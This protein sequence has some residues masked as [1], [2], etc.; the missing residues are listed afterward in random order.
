[1]PESPRP[2]NVLWLID[3]VCWD[4]SLHGGGRLFY[5]LLPEFDPERVRVI[6]CF[7]RASDD[8]RRVF[9]DAP[10]PPIILDK[11]KY[12]PTTLAAILG[13]CRRHS[14]DV[15]HLFC[16]ASSTFGRLVGAILGIPTV[17]H[18]FDTQ[19]YFPYPLYLKIADRLL[20]AGTRRAIAASP[21][22]RSYMRDVRRIPADR[23]ELMPHAIPEE[24]F[25]PA[26]SREEARAALGW[27]PDEIV[28]CAATK[29]GPDRGNE[30]LLRAFARV[31]AEQ[32]RARLVIVYKPTYYHRVPESYAGI[33]WIHDTAY[34]RAEIQKLAD[35]LGLGANVRFVESLDHPD[36]Y[37]TASDV[38]VVPFEDERFSSVHLLEACAR[39]RPAVVTDLGEQ[40]E[41]IQHERSGLRVPPSDEAALAAA[42][43]RLAADESLRRRLGEG[44]ATRAAEFRVKAVAD[45]LAQLYEDLAAGRTRP[46]GGC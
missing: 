17:I 32:P 44:A 26:G 20:A 28:F 23:I 6:P 43:L 21:L 45:R 10:V 34:M 29:L 19:I 15:M 1:M 39:G 7:L 12:D 11:A 4:G 14:I 8:V 46:A 38:T 22:C 40:R 5:N 16:Y 3:H 42:M 36:P 27:E 37:V 13:L 9:A 33:S 31:V 30:T 35:E 2:L 18:D 41:V 25:A 24:K